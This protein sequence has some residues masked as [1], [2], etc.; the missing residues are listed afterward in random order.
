[1][2]VIDVVQSPEDGVDKETR[3]L[4]DGPG[5]KLTQLTLRRGKALSEHASPDPAI[6]ECVSGTGTLT[7]RN[8]EVALV[9]GRRVVLEAGEPHGVAAGDLL[10][11]VLTR[12]TGAA[13]P[14][15]HST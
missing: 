1:M 14:T 7:S 6:I 15:D 8:V 9:P 10:A 13:R 2:N 4:F 11:I 12:F 3:L 5:L